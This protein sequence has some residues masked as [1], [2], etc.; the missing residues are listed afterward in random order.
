[1]TQAA[2]ELRATPQIHF[3]RTRLS[4]S[5]AARAKPKFV[6]WSVFLYFCCQLLLLRTYEKKQVWIEAGRIATVL[7]RH[8]DH[9]RLLDVGVLRV[10]E[11]PDHD[12]SGKQ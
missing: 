12:R 5:P 4:S 7:T 9:G 1:M 11:V 8:V 6:L 2:L 10:P 3:L